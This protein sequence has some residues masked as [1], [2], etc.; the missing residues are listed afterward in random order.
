MPRVV[1]DA[2]DPERA[3]V[4]WQ[5]I[6]FSGGTHGGE[7]FFARTTDGG[8]TFSDPANLSA[9]KAGD[10]KGRLDEKTWD[11]GSLALASAPDGALHAA[12]TEY[13]GALW[14]RRSTDGGATWT[15]PTRVAGTPSLPARA[16]S[17]AA[18]TG[19]VVW[20]A[21]AV[22][23]DPRS[24]VHVTRSIDGGRSFGPPATVGDAGGHSDAPHIAIDRDGT[25]HLVWIERPGGRGSP[26]SELRHARAPRAAADAPV[27]FERPST[28]ASSA[29]S[30]GIAADAEGRVCVLWERV[31]ADGARVGLGLR[32]STDG[33]VRFAASG[34]VPEVGGAGL[35]VN[36]SQQGMLAEKLATTAAGGLVV[37]NSTFDAG[38]A[39][40]VR[41]V[42]GRLER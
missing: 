28:L 21:W 1:A 12:W 36:G 40:R 24:D 18:S 10:G 31:R 34:E 37:V 27:T 22:G 6:V 29:S 16:P 8:R 7:I 35:G 26:A 25:V 41:L 42:R 11:N 14:L 2:A 4:L 19:S 38:R 39:S 17:I 9:S 3:Y 23:E 30:P 20:A 13:E 32:C 15:D 33:G 5:E